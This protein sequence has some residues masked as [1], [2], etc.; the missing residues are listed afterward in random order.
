MMK[1]ILCKLFGH[2]YDVI[3]KPVEYW[4]IGI[5]WLRCDRC[6]KDFALNDRVKAI[7]PMDFEIQDM[8]KWQKV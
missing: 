7:I 3:A 2:R 1:S 8:H 4:A 5:R 6:L